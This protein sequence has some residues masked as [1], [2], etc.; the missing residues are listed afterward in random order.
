MTDANQEQSSRPYS[1]PADEA[2]KALKTNRKQSTNQMTDANR[3]QN[4]MV[5]SHPADKTE[6]V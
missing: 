1:H 5:C 6:K 4:N 2:R 3:N